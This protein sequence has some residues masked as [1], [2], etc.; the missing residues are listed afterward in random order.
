MFKN[1]YWAWNGVLSSDFCDF[2]LK[3]LDWENAE[4]ASTRN[5]PEP[6]M[7]INNEKMIDP[8]RRITKVIWQNFNTPITAVAYYYTLMANEIAGWNFDV[9]HPEEV[10]LGRYGVGGHYIW[11]ND[12]M[13]PNEISFQ[14]KLSCT[15]LLNDVSEYDGGLLE[16]KGVSEDKL[17]P[18]TKGSVIIFPSMLEHRVTPVTRGERFSAVCWSNGPAF[19]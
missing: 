2:V 10:Q 8:T 9:K 13:V 6:L 12:C 15:I 5:E 3:D 1:M 17:P 19:K 16:I 14:R 4:N 18:T 11:H 7:K